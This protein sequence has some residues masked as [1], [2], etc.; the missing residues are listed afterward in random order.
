M[1][2]GYFDTSALMR[3]VER[4]IPQ[5]RDVNMR[6]G[7]AVQ[8]LL[9]GDD[10]L[11]LS[12]LT[13]IEFRSAVSRDWRRTDPESVDLDAAWA[14]RAR[15]ALMKQISDERIAIVANPP[16]A[17]EHA[18]TLVDMAAMEHGFALGAWDAIH[19]ITA[20]AWA[21]QERSRVILYT[22]DDDYDGFVRLYPHFTTY[23]D[24]VDLDATTRQPQAG[25]TG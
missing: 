6:A 9:E 22:S 16:K 20:C 23:V 21:Y 10:R 1:T 4:D 25:G 17:A 11:A 14:E 15:S 5:P 18:M 8:R 24:I 3:W 2:L 12:E 7:G 19:L 13:L